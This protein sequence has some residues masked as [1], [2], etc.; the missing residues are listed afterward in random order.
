MKNATLDSLD[1]VVC[2]SAST[3]AAAVRDGDVSSVELVDACLRR[4]D[5]VNPRLNAVVQL[6]S[7]SARAAARTADAARAGREPLGPLHGVPATIKDAFDVR[8]VVSTAGTAGRASHM[9]DA[10]ATAVA[11]LRA[12]GAIVLGKTNLPELSLAFES[13]NDIYGR[14]A[15]PYDQSRTCGGSSG[16]EA[17]I[18]AAGGSPLGLGT[19]AA[20]SIRVP[21]H[22]CG[23]A[24]LKPTRGRVPMTG[25]FPPPLGHT[26]SLWHAGPLARR[27][28]D[29]ALALSI[30]SGPDGRD[31]TC[32]PVPLRS[33]ADLDLPRLRVAVHTHN[34]I[35]APTPETVATRRERTS[36]GGRRTPGE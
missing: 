30:I 22:F 24:G 31:P 28:E 5:A 1:D 29:L 6:A 19:D 17:A 7:D 18:I 32:A 27:V 11:R 14:T 12:A 23:V 10:D 9:P 4:I 34:G 33:S 25:A 3:L 26:A 13:N 2:A 36:A 16:G 8:G 15:N 20:G 21:A 35:A